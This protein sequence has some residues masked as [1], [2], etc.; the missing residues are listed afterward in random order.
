MSVTVEVEFLL[1]IVDLSVTFAV[2]F[3]KFY[4]RGGIRTLI[5]FTTCAVV[6]SAVLQDGRRARM[7]DIACVI[8]TPAFGSA[9][10]KFKQSG[11]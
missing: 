11:V 3:N 7:G 10:A 5:R 8:N 4:T 9:F 6:L 1:A 2:A